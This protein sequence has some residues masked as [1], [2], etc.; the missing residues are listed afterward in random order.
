MTLQR[1]VVAL[2]KYVLHDCAS[3]VKIDTSNVEKMKNMMQYAA[4]QGVLPFLY[5][6]PALQDTIK[7]QGY[8]S[9]IVSGLYLQSVQ[10]EE[11]KKILNTC[12][13]HRID[14]V[15]LKGSVTREL[16]PNPVLR[17][18]G[19]IDLLYRPEHTK[20]LQRA[21]ESIGYQHGGD[22]IKHD[23]YEKANIL[24]EMHKTL[25]VPGWPEQEYFDTIWDRVQKRKGY[26][27]VYDMTAE[28]HYLFTFTHLV[29]HFKMSGIGIRMV[30][31]VYVLA[32][33]RP[34]NWECVDGIL[35][36]LDLKRFHASIRKLAEV[37]F[38][39]GNLTDITPDS[40]LEL[41][42]YIL[43]GGV[44]G[45]RDNVTTNTQLQYKSKW[46]ML[47]TM[48]FPSYAVMKTVYAWVTTPVLLPVA[49]CCRGWSAMMKRRKNITTQLDK[50]KKY[51][52]V[53][54][55]LSEREQFFQE[56]GLYKIKECQ[57]QK[58]I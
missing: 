32:Q 58:K 21:M 9:R 4:S 43:N 56:Y 52:S 44:F 11:L 40:L 34:I 36:Q 30:L 17:T 29:E 55:K 31:D 27:H 39:P 54:H 20:E 45:S 8:Y 18:M 38:S 15:P 16:Y 7:R 5:E 50:V 28:D 10:S 22:M 2:I 24:V 48:V 33:N 42:Q 46:Q 14:C 23:H 47:R 41:E 35:T 53:G 1:E 13:E 26:E 49:W 57:N 51:E 19:D 37:W 3:T 25:G 12:E 6:Y